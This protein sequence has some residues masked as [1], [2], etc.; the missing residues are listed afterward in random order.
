MSG[1]SNRHVQSQ[2]QSIKCLFQVPSESWR[3]FKVI[4]D[5][6]R[7]N[8]LKCIKSTLLFLEYYILLKVMAKPFNHDNLRSMI[9]WQH[10]CCYKNL[11]L[12]VSNSDKLRHVE[13][14]FSFV[15]SYR[16]NWLLLWCPHSP[17][18]LM[19]RNSLEIRTERPGLIRPWPWRAA[20]VSWA[21]WSCST[22][23][24][25]TPTIL[26]PQPDCIHAKHCSGAG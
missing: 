24:T 6:T 2:N 11:T 26:R 23:L 16:N 10:E 4:P 3:L 15:V 20:S 17:D 8:P 9:Q 18:S 5:M 19:S 13:A 7:Q 14:N 21:W 12:L 25:R 22:S 1:K